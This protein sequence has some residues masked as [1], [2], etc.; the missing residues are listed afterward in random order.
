M[1]NSK[2]RHTEGAFKIGVSKLLIKNPTHSHACILY[3]ILL[4]HLEFLSSVVAAFAAF[5]WDLRKKKNKRRI[6]LWKLYVTMIC[7][8]GFAHT[9][10]ATSY[11][12]YVVQVLIPTAA[13]QSQSTAILLAHVPPTS[14]KKL[15]RFIY[16]KYFF[17]LKVSRKTMLLICQGLL[18][19]KYLNIWKLR[20]GKKKVP[21]I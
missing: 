8:L 2:A 13:F 1:Q 15:N 21:L 17:F 9:R 12:A 20:G 18:L 10:Q 14:M 11:W 4:G 3:H 19:G 16:F 6:L 5:L 7:R